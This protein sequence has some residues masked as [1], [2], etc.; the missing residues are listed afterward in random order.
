[1][2]LRSIHSSLQAS[3]SFQI[4][5]VAKRLKSWIKSLAGILQDPNLLYC[6]Y[7]MRLRFTLKVGSRCGFCLLHRGY[8]QITR[9]TEKE[10]IRREVMESLLKLLA[11]EFSD[12]AV[13]AIIGSKRDR[14]IRGITGCKDPYYNLKKEANESALK[15]LP[16]LERLINSASMEEHLRI[17]CLIACI[18]NII[19]YDVPDHSDDF[20]EIFDRLDKEFF[21]ID[22]LDLFEAMIKRDIN[23]LYL[24]DNAGEI[25]FDRLVVRVLRDRGCRVTVAVKGG[26]SLNDALLE[27]AEEVG[28]VEEADQVITTGS[29][30]VGINL[31]ESSKEFMEA[32]HLAD[33]ILSK[34]MANWETLTEY[35]APCPTLFL[36]RTKCE[37]VARA[38]GAPLQMN[39]AKLVEEGWM[40]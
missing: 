1:M 19:E 40:L 34:G 35:P 26:P 15:M 20:S 10:E 31:S 39:I 28:M 27:D 22:D 23:L 12:D 33:V 11:S 5:D 3:L 14:I 30:A 29:D 8:Q 24:T 7:L 36:F 13:A 38:V 25:V 32:Y 9:A 18:G 37:P 21:Y 2:A 17:A 4:S 6:I 16:E